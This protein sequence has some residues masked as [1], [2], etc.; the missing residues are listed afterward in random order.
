VGTG[1]ASANLGDREVVDQLSKALQVAREAGS[2]GEE[3]QAAM[4]DIIRESQRLRTRLGLADGS[5]SVATVA[6]RR[7]ESV[8]AP[9]ARVALVGVGPMCQYLARRLPERGF[10]VSVAN[11]TAVKA[12]ALGLPTVPL[13]Q[14][15]WDPTGFDALVTATASARPIFTLEAWRHLDR[16]PL[17]LLDLALPADSEPMLSRLPWVLREDLADFQRETQATRDLRREAALAAEP[18]LDA[19]IQRLIKRSGERDHRHHLKGAHDR[20]SDAWEALE[21]EA[22]SPGNP[23]AGLS[24]EQKA[25]LQS[26]LRRGRTL[27]FRTLSHQEGPGVCPMG[28]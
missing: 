5:A 15:Q 25:A 26:L 23:L 20:L 12:Q 9:G 1:L 22:C 14:L 4:E 18:H 28:H 16:P 2:A 19:A 27:A 10:Q 24:P 17:H 3:A 11:R 6:L 13:E 21:A 8:L 7:L